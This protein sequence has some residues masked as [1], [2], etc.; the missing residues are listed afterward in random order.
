MPRWT[1]EEY[2]RYQKDTHNIDQRNRACASKE[3]LKVP[4]ARKVDH[5]PEIPGMDETVQVPYT[6]SVVCKYSDERRRDLDGALST[7]LDCIVDVAKEINDDRLP[8]DDRWR[9]VSI[10]NVFGTKVPKG[11]EGAI[12]YIQYNQPVNW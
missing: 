11:D 8:S 9:M 10:G 3:E 7:L 6:I 1:K 4:C 2:E 12:I 5:Q